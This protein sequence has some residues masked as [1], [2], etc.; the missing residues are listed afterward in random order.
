MDKSYH[1]GKSDAGGSKHS[2]ARVL[3]GDAELTGGAV[4]DYELCLSRLGG[5]RELFDEILEI[6]LEDAPAL[7]AQASTSLANGDWA[8][9][10]RATH[11]LKGLSA[12]FAAA[13]AVTASYTVE[14][15]AREHRLQSAAQ[16]FPLLE[17]EMLRL[18]TALR[19]FR[20]QRH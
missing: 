4:F 7:L 3:S 10:E 13:A 20:Q 19:A 12:N 11:T 14:L 6:F 2:R 15:H 5:D 8:T 18:E 1:N 17:A 16:C 9:L